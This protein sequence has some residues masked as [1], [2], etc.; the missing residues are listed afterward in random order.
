MGN[1][2]QAAAEGAEPSPGLSS[3][4][5]EGSL[6]ADVRA[7]GG[8]GGSA[9]PLRGRAVFQQGLRTHA[10]GNRSWLSISMKRSPAHAARMFRP[11]RAG[12]LRHGP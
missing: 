5:H 10:S 8:W 9:V 7:S 11:L 4:G 12:M 6:D 1:S 3:E 2:A